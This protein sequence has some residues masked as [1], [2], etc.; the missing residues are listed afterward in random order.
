MSGTS[1]DGIDAGLVDFSDDQCRVVDFHY[2]PFSES[3][4]QQI[5]HLSQPEQPILLADYG[6]MDT[7]LGRLFAETVIALL[8]KPHYRP[9]RLTRSAVT[10]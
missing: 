4:K 5:R 1:L 10:A 7:R 6:S 8:K 9:S 2:L 3:L